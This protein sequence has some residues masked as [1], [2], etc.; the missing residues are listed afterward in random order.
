[1]CGGAGKQVGM[2]IYYLCDMDPQK[3]KE[4]IG[5]FATVLR[6]NFHSLSSNSPVPFANELKITK[7]YLDVEQTRYEHKLEVTFHIEETE[8]MLPP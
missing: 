4:V 1:M 5:N 2:K 8:F 3:A 6:G 7:A